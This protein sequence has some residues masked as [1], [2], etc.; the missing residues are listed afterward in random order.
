MKIDTLTRRWIRNESDERAAANGCWF[1]E[2]RAEHVIT[3]AERFLCLYEGDYAGQPL[4]P[5]DWQIE[6]GSRLFGW[7][8]FDEDWG[9]EVRR[10][11]K[12]E[13]QQRAVQDT[14]SP[15]HPQP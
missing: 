7:V 10:F 5:S 12:A 8:R 3:F 1:D 9:R 14:L 11:R 4:I 2:A 6:C 13:L 15:T